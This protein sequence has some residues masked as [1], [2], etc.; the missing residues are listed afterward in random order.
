M[1]QK[2]TKELN[3]LPRVIAEARAE[4]GVGL[5]ATQSLEEFLS[6]EAVSFS[7]SCGFMLLLGYWSPQAMGQRL[8]RREAAEIFR[9]VWNTKRVDVLIRGL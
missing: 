4:L 6:S 3:A 5:L 2:E 8:I 7:A 9:T 1:L